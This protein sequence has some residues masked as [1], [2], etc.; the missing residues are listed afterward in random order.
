MT[1]PDASSSEMPKVPIPGLAGRDQDELLLDMILDRRPL[2]PGA[3]PGMHALADKSRRAGG[4]ARWRRAARRG[5]SVGCLPPLGLAGQHSDAGRRAAWAPRERRRLASWSRPAVCCHCR[6][7][8]G[9]VRH[10]RRLRGRAAGFGPGFR[11]S[12][13]RR[14]GRAPCRPSSA[15]RV[16]APGRPP[17]R[18][19][20]IAADGWLRASGQAR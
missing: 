10:G 7:S 4:S 20:V 19:A 18:R 12:H 11:P 2:P 14:A 15:W 3:P 17:W 5:S 16:P 6:D 1:G 13:H 9:L 8:G